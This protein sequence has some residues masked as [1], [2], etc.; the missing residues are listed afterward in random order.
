MDVGTAIGIVSQVAW[1][2][3]SYSAARITR[4]AIAFVHK[5]T[6]EID[7]TKHWR[8]RRVFD[9][10]T[11]TFGTGCPNRKLGLQRVELGAM[12]DVALSKGRL[13]HA[14]AL[15]VCYEGALRVDE[16]CRLEIQHV[17]WSGH[18]ATLL[19]KKSKTDPGSMG[20][21]V[22]LRTR[23]GAPF[24][25]NVIL[26]RWM[27]RLQRA[28]GPLITPLRHGTPSNTAYLPRE[29]T[30]MIKEYAAIIGMNPRPIGSHSCRSGW[31]TE[32][33]DLGRPEAQVAAHLRHATLDML[34]RYYRPRRA[35]LNLTQHADPG[36][37]A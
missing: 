9:G 14:V 5:Q 12:I 8:F 34:L 13:D 37:I 20:A 21:Y 24:D 6:G 22:D 32:E 35:P 1:S 16:L 23:A 26:A 29:F 31:A 36:R 4:E 30:R 2:E 33:L 11:R 27:K 3:Q 18:G 7:P 10:I 19:V 15:A 17:Y 28:D 25:A